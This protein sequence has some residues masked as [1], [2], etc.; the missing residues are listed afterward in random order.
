MNTKQILISFLALLFCQNLFSQTSTSPTQTVC[1]GS[2][3][4]YKVLA[5]INSTYQWKVLSAP[6]SFGTM[7][8]LVSAQNDSVSI[9]WNGAIGTY[10]LQ[11]VEIDSNGC[12]GVPSIVSVNLVSQPSAISPI[13]NVTSCVN[14]PIA[15]LFVPGSNVNWYTDTLGSTSIFNGNTYNTGQTTANQYVYYV[16]ETNISGCESKYAS[17]ILDIVAQP[18]VTLTASGNNVCLNDSLFLSA[19]GASSYSWNNGVV[20]P[21]QGITA[22]VTGLNNFTVIGSDL[23]GCL[24]TASISVQVNQLPN[25]VASSAFNSICLGD[26]IL[27]SASGA[28]NYQWGN[29]VQSSNQYVSPTLIGSNSYVV[30]GSD[31]NSCSNL[32]TI[33][34]T[35]NSL[36]IAQVTAS[37]TNICINDTI[38]LTSSSASNY[39]WSNGSNS[40]SQTL[41]ISSPGTSVFTVTIFDNNSCSARDSVSVNVNNNPIISA[42]ANN[43]NICIGD[44]VTLSALGAVNYQWDNGVTTSTQVITPST[45]ATLTYT[46]VGTDINSCSANAQVNIIV[47]PLPNTGPIF[48]N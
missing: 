33:S 12:E 35:V 8:S 22:S 24:D 23:N 19:S 1:W 7:D 41:T 28:L 25:V 48:H 20:S 3:E 14:Q 4:P 17:I 47:N 30:A 42:S 31:V 44:N 6:S 26:S 5:N 39:Q 15:S 34:I 16:T 10:D 2:V 37:D 21:S 40:Q 13:S 36:P 27:I 45:A 46:V 11:V 32:D 43:N 38:T 29:G 18:N 9:L